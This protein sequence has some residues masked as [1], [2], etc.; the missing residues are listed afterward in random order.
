MPV[1]KQIKLGKCFWQY[2]FRTCG[3]SRQKT[4]CAAGLRKIFDIP[5]HI[6]E[7]W[8]TPHKYPKKDRVKITIKEKII[9]IDKKDRSIYYEWLPAV[10]R[11]IKYGYSY[12]SIEY[13]E[14]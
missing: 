14:D 10:K 4:I 9:Y 1:P 13:I 6:T 8:L 5:D 2:S 3:R 12:L 11:W 7:L